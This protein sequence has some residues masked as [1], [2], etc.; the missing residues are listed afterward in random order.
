MSFIG[1][2]TGKKALTAQKKKNYEKAHKLYRQAMGKGMNSLP[3]LMSYTGLM[4]RMAEYEEA[5]DVLKRTE[6]MTGL[7]ENERTEIL[8][9][10]AIVLWKK[11]HLDHAMELLRERL[12]QCK[13]G[14]LY[15]VAGYLAVEQGNAETALSINREAIEY[16][17]SDPIFLDNMG[18]T[19]FRLYH[20]KSKAKPYFLRA[21]EIKPEAIDTNY[22]L[23]LM[24]IEDGNHDKAVQRLE[25]ARKGSFSPLNYATPDKIENALKELLHDD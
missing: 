23:A 18:Q 8:A 9:N 16:D 17:E 6:R 13:N 19:F 21:L 2:L 12:L 20:D 1:N 4:L 7:T 25:L 24:D 5:L 10:Y 15:S 22:F 3:L 11:G 14:L